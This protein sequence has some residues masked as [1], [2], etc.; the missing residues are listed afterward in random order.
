MKNLAEIIIDSKLNAYTS[1]QKLLDTISD[2]AKINRS[3][4]AYYDCFTTDIIENVDYF[5]LH[6]L[7]QLLDE[8]VNL[9]SAIHKNSFIRLKFD[10]GIILILEQDNLN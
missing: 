9:P 8:Q 5:T 1:C 7:A 6:E 4:N 10:W 3:K 2:L